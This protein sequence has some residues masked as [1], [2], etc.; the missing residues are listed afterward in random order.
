[1]LLSIGGWFLLAN[2]IRALDDNLAADTDAW[3]SDLSSDGQCAARLAKQLVAHGL[4]L[5][6]ASIFPSPD[7]RFG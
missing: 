1:M 4:E 5:V 2:F 6:D 3:N 7:S